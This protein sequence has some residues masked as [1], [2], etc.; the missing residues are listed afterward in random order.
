MNFWEWVSL[1]SLCFA[2]AASPGPSLAVV[3][4]ASVSGGKLAG[5]AAAWAHALGVGIYAT[6][7][8]LGLNTLLSQLGGL[9]VALQTAGALY[10]LW[11]AWGILRSA[12]SDT[13]A[14]EAAPLTSATISARDGFAVAFLNPKLAVF[15]LALFSQFL[16]PDA[17]LAHQG[18][19]IA[20]ATL[21]D[22]SWYTLITLAFSRDKW[23]QALRS[24]A[25]RIDRVFAVLLTLVAAVILLR[26]FQSL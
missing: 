6:L 20:T 14:Q 9:F 8:V 18:I 16:R 4:R 25:A 12:P 15:M 21:I 24:N 5:L 13:E 7:T 19:L 23:T 1:A 2:G 26:V 17:T 22:G 3:V 11:L 10:L